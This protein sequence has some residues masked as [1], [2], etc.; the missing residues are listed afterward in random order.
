LSTGNFSWNSTLTFSH[1]KNEVLQLVDGLTING[2]ASLD[3]TNQ[4]LT[5][6]KVGEPIGVFYGYETEGLFRTVDDLNN[7]PIQFGQPVGDASVIGRTWLGDVKF[8]DV[9]GDGVVDG[10]DRTVIG[11]PHPDFTFGWQN[12][13]NY[14][15]FDLGVFVQ[16]SYGNEIFNGLNRSLTGSNLVYRNQ[17][18]S[19]T[20]YWNIQNPNATHP[21]YTSNS[22]PNI[23]ISDRYVEDGSYLRI[24][25]VRLGYQIPAKVFE[26]MGLSKVNIYTSVQN[27]YT[28]T[29]YSGYDPE[30]GALNQNPLLTGMD[31]G[32]YPIP[33]TFT[34]G[35]DIDF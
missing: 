12:T 4:V 26:K 30:V 24:Q 5:E 32:R 18:E 14:K 16:G 8:K 3:D 6:T 7:A 21:R 31:N 11:S 35:V 29:N 25:N 34:F 20:D 15:G 1:Y 10:S 28:F 19:V 22:T 9:N 27:L 23:L 13:F 17:L 2:Q 33:R